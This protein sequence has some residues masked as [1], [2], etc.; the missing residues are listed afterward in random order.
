MEK[1]LYGKGLYVQLL[2]SYSEYCKENNIEL[3]NNLNLTLNNRILIHSLE[4]LKRILQQ[5]INWL[6]TIKNE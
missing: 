2:K 3:N 4:Y 6:E 5:T 1:Q